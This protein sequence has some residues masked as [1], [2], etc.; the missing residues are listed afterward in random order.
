MEERDTCQSG[1]LCP[2]CDRPY[3]C[4]HCHCRCLVL[5]PVARAPVHGVGL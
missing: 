3:C 4:A 1:R 5:D 2:D